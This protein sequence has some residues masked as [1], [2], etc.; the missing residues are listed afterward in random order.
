MK[1]GSRSFGRGRAGL[2]WEKVILER[3]KANLGRTGK[4]HVGT[5]LSERRSQKGT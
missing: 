5:R 1:T 2:G 4:G 3:G